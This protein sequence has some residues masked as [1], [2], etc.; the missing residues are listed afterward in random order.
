M[1]AA[2]SIAW[3]R[4]VPVIQLT[5]SVYA[6]GDTLRDPAADGWLDFYVVLVRE[7][8]DGRVPALTPRL[9][10]LAVGD[11]LNMGE[12]ITGHFTLAPV[13]PG[14]NVVFLGT[15]TG[16]APHNSMLCDLLRAGHTGRIL[17]ACCVRYARDLG[18]TPIHARLTQTVR[19]LGL[20]QCPSRH[21]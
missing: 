10:K 8:P 3:S 15:G 16:E 4:A 21:S 9:F 7:N 6:D 5:T 11:R 20:S 1:C 12:K 19:G 17:N 18:Y 2:A 14:D 13:K